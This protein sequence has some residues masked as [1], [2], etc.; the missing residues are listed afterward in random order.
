MADKTPKKK[1][2]SAAAPQSKEKA[3]RNVQC[4]IMQC[5]CKNPYQD[6]L[7]GYSIRL[8]NPK[9]GGFRCTVC[10]TTK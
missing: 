6:K 10:G 8:H 2:E 3:S 1:V 7:Y 9:S 4:K 5:S